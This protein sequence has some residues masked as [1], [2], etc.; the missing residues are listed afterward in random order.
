MAEK[1]M[2]SLAQ[3]Y[4]QILMGFLSEAIIKFQAQKAQKQAEPKLLVAS[5]GFQSVINRIQAAFGD[6]NLEQEESEQNDFPVISWQE[7]TSRFRNYLAQQQ[8]PLEPK[9]FQAVFADLLKLVI[10]TTA[11]IKQKDP[12][13]NPMYAINTRFFE[14]QEIEKSCLNLREALDGKF[15]KAIKNLVAKEILLTLALT[16]SISEEEL[17]YLPPQYCRGIF[18]Q[19]FGRG[20]LLAMLR[21][22]GIKYGPFMKTVDLLVQNNILIEGCREYNNEFIILNPSLKPFSVIR[23]LIHAFERTQQETSI[24]EVETADQETSPLGSMITIGTWGGEA[25]D[26]YLFE[27]FEVGLEGL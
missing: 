15:Q 9:I 7:L 3:K 11:G 18:F 25:R 5:P 6:L 23:E 26:I 21:G 2:G 10:F 1:N 19:R 20:I 17:K 12:Q 8:I 13:K 16:S 14:K 22:R 4:A 27:G 24:I